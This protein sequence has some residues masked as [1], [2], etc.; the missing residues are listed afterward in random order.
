MESTYQMTWKQVTPTSSAA[1]YSKKI[2]HRAQAAAH[3]DMEGRV[4]RYMVEFM[5]WCWLQHAFSR[6][7]VMIQN[8]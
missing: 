7:G 6:L 1:S 8:G 5:G 2:G 4:A 3:E